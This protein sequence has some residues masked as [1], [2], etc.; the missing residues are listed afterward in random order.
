MDDTPAEARKLD[1]L[2]ERMFA[3][4]RTRRAAL[5]PATLGEGAMPIIAWVDGSCT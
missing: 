1:A 2:L 3:E 4:D 5:S